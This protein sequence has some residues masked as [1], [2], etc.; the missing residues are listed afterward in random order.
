[1]GGSDNGECAFVS[2][3]DRH[4]RVRDFSGSTTSPSSDVDSALPIEL[5]SSATSSRSSP[6]LP[7]EEPGASREPGRRELPDVQLHKFGGSIVNSVTI[8]RLPGDEKGSAAEDIVVLRYEC[9]NMPSDRGALIFPS[10]SQ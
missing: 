2:V 3:V 6:R 4:G 7:G 5:G 9:G 8:H 1:M 10:H